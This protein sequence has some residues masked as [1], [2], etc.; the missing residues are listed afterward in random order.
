MCAATGI[1][2]S[3][4][5]TAGPGSVIANLSVPDVLASDRDLDTLGYSLS[6]GN[7]EQVCV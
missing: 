3:I 5:E 7:E 2:V 4:P 6:F 1:A